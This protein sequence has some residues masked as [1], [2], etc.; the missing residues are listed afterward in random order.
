MALD[1]SVDT[2]PL[3]G[4]LWTMVLCMVLAGTVG[5]F[6]F[7]RLP[8]PLNR[9]LIMASIFSGAYAFFKYLI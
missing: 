2:G 9:I 1:L 3:A 8:Y 5:F 4:M 7:K 6:L